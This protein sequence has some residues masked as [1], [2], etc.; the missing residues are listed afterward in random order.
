MCTVAAGYKKK[1][2]LKMSANGFLF[3]CWIHFL[4]ISDYS[5]TFLSKVHFALQLIRC[6]LVNNLASIQSDAFSYKCL[7]KSQLKPSD[8]L[9]PPRVKEV[10]IAYQSLTNCSAGFFQSH[11]QNDRREIRLPYE[12]LA[13]S[14]SILLLNS[15]QKKALTKVEMLVVLGKN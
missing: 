3:D 11:S 12:T 2:S 7:L 13:A 15:W 10:C 9:Q 8:T 1:T 4:F 14:A 5:F 6:V